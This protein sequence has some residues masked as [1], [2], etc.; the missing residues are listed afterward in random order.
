MIDWMSALQKIKVVREDSALGRLRDKRLKLQ[1]AD[2]VLQ[3]R[4]RA[5]RES[6]ATLAE[7]ENALFKEILKRIVDTDSIEQVKEKVQRLHSYHQQL[8]IDLEISLQQTARLTQE[9][10]GAVEQYRIAQT[11]RV[12]FDDITDDARREGRRHEEEREEA[13]RDDAFAKRGTN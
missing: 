5:V 11:K 1:Q 12:K 7:R 13:D 6:E 3:E 9:V 8:Q 2:Q 4:S 10:E